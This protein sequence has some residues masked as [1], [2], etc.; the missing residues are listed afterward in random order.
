M[1]EISTEQ[2]LRRL[3]ESLH[4]LNAAAV[5]LI[6]ARPDAAT[7]ADEIQGE[8]KHLQRTLTAAMDDEFIMSDQEIDKI[9]SAC[10]DVESISLALDS[11]GRAPGIGPLDSFSPHLVFLREAI[12]R[13]VDILY[14][15]DVTP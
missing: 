3:E 7:I 14:R 5:F 13:A 12:R 4:T 8:A 6:A 15:D 11:V 9:V 10:D 2:A 1:G